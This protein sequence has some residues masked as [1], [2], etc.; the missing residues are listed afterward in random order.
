MHPVGGVDYPQT[1][2]DFDEWFA[3]E[4]ECLEFLTRIRWADGFSCPGC[5]GEKA[6]RNG[7]EQMHCSQC[8]RQTSAKAG[9]IFEGTRKPLRLWFH[10][11]WMVT[12]Q[13]H[14]V[15]ALGVKRVLGLGSYRTAWSW[16]HKLRR[17]MVRPGRDNLTGE[18][19]VDETY[20]GG[21][22]AGVSGRKT[23]KKSIV[24]I[25]AE[26]RGRG[27]GRVRMA[28]VPDASGDSLLPFVQNAVSQGS[29]VAT[30]GWLGYKGLRKLGYE[31]LPQNLSASGDPAHVAMPRVHRVAGLLDRWWLGTYQGGISGRHLD[32][33]LDEYTFRFNRRRS[34]A[35]GLLFYRLVEQAVQGEPAPYKSMVGGKDRPDH[36]M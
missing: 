30:D 10:A 21:V 36:K 31:H 29:V 23:E 17:A 22:E 28:R 6:W 33:Y 35:R 26:V 3:S 34:R 1:I 16:L 11:M 19:E 24:V 12:S 18:V 7:R 2:Q 27:I 20:I 32:Y 4:A 9:T 13:K 14:G 8:Q 5:G 15:S 25:A